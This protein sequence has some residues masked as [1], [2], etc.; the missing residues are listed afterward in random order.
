M[1]SQEY[2]ISGPARCCLLGSRD[3]PPLS[4]NLPVPAEGSDGVGMT[5]QY[6]HELALPPQRRERG[7]LVI[8]ALMPGRENPPAGYRQP[9]TWID[10]SAAD[11]CFG[12]RAAFRGEI[13]RH[14][15]PPSMRTWSGQT[16][17]CKQ[18]RTERT[19]VG[20][21]IGM[22]GRPVRRQRAIA[23]TVKPPRPSPPTES[24]SCC[25]TDFAS[26]IRA[27]GRGR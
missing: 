24:W 16:P 3:R 4:V 22:P 9:L 7:F 20:S 11:T 12:R 27:V 15:M 10:R 13:R 23:V 6:E 25:P 1:N 17:A 19:G 2:L 18:A 8:P 5:W 21:S 14:A 26:I